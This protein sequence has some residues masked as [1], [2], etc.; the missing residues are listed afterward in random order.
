[1]SAA[2]NLGKCGLQRISAGHHLMTRDRQ[3]PITIFGP[4]GV[5]ALSGAVRQYSH[6]NLLRRHGL[7]KLDN[8]IDYAGADIDHPEPVQH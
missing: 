6:G 1:M 7:E 3:S 2:H 5:S 8:A 4:A